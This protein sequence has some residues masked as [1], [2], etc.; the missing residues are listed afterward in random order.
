MITIRSLLTTAATAIRNSTAIAT[1]CSTNFSGAVIKIFIGEDKSTRPTE[2]DAPYVVLGPPLDDYDKGA[3]TEQRRPG[4]EV[5]FAIFKE[6]RYG[7]A[8]AANDTGLTRSDSNNTITFDGLILAD[9]LGDLILT[10]L[11]TAFTADGEDHVHIADYMLNS[12]G[13]LWEGGISIK[14]N[15][16]C[17]MG[18]PSL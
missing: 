8:T 11:V 17:G 18:E 4:F 12:M 13:P 3:A 16:E 6:C 7:G 9:Q 10:E 15:Y 2:D 1:F 5:D 14:L